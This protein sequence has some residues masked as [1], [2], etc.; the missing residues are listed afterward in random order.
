VKKHLPSWVR[1]LAR[2]LRRDTRHEAQQATAVPLGI[3]RRLR[4]QAI[5]I[6]NT[7]IESMMMDRWDTT[8]GHLPAAPSN[9]R[10]NRASTTAGGILTEI[11]P[12]G[13]DGAA[14][15]NHRL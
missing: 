6:L 2:V 5:C 15:G 11:S 12:Q 7:H 13:A 14:R 3:P 10:L 4:Q 8:L 9:T 1:L